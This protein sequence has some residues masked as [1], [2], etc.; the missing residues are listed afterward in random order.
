MRKGE[1]DLKKS[2]NKMMEREEEEE[3]EGKNIILDD[4]F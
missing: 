1:G 4:H 2:V 3:E